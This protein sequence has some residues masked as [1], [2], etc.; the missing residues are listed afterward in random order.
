MTKMTKFRNFNFFLF[1]GMLLTGFLLV[2]SNNTSPLYPYSYGIDS[3]FYRYMGSVILQ[4][5]TPYVDLWE[6][7]GPVLYFIQ[8][9]GALNGTRNEKLSFIFIMQIFSLLFSVIFLYKINQRISVSKHSS[10]RFFLLLTVALSVLGNTLEGGNLTEE[11]SIPMICCSLYLFINYA[12]QTNRNT[13]HPCKYSYIHGICL[14]LITFIRINNAVSIFAGLLVIGINLLLKR[15]WKDFLKNILFG[16][17]GSLTVIIP[18]FIWF[19]RRNALNEMIYGTFIFNLKYSSEM[20]QNISKSTWLFLCLPVFASLLLVLL[21]ILKTHHF[22]LIDNIV[23]V[24]AAANLLMFTKIY[25]YPHYFIIL[26]PFFLLAMILYVNKSNILTVIISIIVFAMCFDKCEKSIRYYLS[27]DHTLLFSSA[28]LYFPKSEKNSAIA[29]DVPSSIYLNVGITPCS[30]FA[31]FQ[32]RIFEIQPK[33]EEEF[34]ETM[35]NKDP[36]W[37]ISPCAIDSIVPYVSTL[38]E[39]RYEYKFNDGSYCFFRQNE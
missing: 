5:K 30:R 17:L 36:K 29:V 35:K 21:H 25:R 11:W 37:I 23:L 26:V 34:I 38:I 39:T 20:P 33:F 10:L 8:A 22:R 12:L 31:A 13:G 16:I 24:I 15:Q 4:G 28:K 27:T 1:L 18:I 3:A 7:K 2:F 32:T 6:H 14:A 9:L 19:F